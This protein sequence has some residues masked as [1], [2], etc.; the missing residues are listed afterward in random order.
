MEPA[1]EEQIRK[2]FIALKTELKF[3]R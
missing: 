3:I 1:A 2:V